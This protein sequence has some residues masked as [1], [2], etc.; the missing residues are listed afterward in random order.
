MLWTTGYRLDYGWID[1]P[2]F[3]EFGYP[4]QRRGVTEVPGL[5]FVGLL[6]QHN[7][8]SATLPELPSSARHVAEQMGL[9]VEA[10]GPGATGLEPR[11]RAGGRSGAPT[12]S[13][14]DQQLGRRHERIA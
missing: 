8:I 5:Y 4:S 12:V 1:L 10:K 9:T 2:I 6:W 3:D 11:G 7:Q 14:A 13:G